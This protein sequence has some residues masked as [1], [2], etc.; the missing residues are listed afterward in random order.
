MDL[1][2]SIAI[3]ALAA[4]GLFQLL[5]RNV[6]RAAMALFLISNAVNL[7]LLSAGAYDGVV[8]AYTTS[9]GP[10]SDALPQA[11]VL[12]AIVIGMGALA[13]VLALVYVISVRYG[14][15][16]TGDVDALQR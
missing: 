8:A 11:L 5:R 4:V 13:L 1:M 9:T 2:T 15:S 12:T 16:D 14:T 10:R 3:G 7:F 6:L